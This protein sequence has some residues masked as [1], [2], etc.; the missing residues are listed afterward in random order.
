MNPGDVVELDVKVAALAEALESHRLGA[1]RLRGQDWFAW[2]TCGGSN[3]VLLASETGIAEVFVD[4]DG[5]RVVTNE[6]ESERLR[7]EE[8]PDRLPVVAFPW[9]DEPRIDELVSTGAN[10]GSVASDIPGAG[11]RALPAELVAAK[12]R[13][14]PAE[15]ER[16]RSV[17]RDAAEALTETLSRVV[18]GMS[19]LEVAAVGAEALLRRG[20][21]PALIL[22]AGS[23][24]MELYRHAP[25]TAEPIGDR[26]GVVF[27]GRRMGLYANLTRFAW[28]RPRTR[29]ER[30]AAEVVAMVEA[31]AFDAS[32]P[33]A[34]LGSTFDVISRAYARLGHA[35]AELAHHQGGTTGYRSR[36]VIARPDDPTMLATP[37]A[38]AWN[39]SL[40]AAKIEDTVLVSDAGIEIL[41]ADPSWPTVEVRGRARPDV[42]V[43][44]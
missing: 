8:V 38:V 6:I 22:V 26:V 1:I 17:G 20:V 31:D 18:P 12:R 9:V 24:R 19:E 2:A 44:S 42:L 14:L 27:C 35:G 25:P 39:P 15:I 40:P 7:T 3:A 11:E 41:T 34:T 33:G 5:V 37:L 16:Y 28:F 32:R 30:A 13:L 21:D 36:E 4:R 10:L 29:D 23:R 43:R